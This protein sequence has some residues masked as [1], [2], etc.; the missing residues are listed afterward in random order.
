MTTNQVYGQEINEFF[1][2]NDQV[3]DVLPSDIAAFSDNAV[4]EESFVR[5]KAVFAF[6]SKYSRGKVIVTLPVSINAFADYD[7]GSKSSQNKG[8]TVLNQLSNFPYCFMNS[9]LNF[10]TLGRIIKQPTLAALQF[11][12]GNS[13]F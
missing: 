10:I 12:I 1:Q 5:S 4:F 9:H 11:K 2:I 3:L 13:P 7:S 8:L 6:R